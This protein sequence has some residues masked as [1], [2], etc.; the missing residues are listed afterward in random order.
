MVWAEAKLSAPGLELAKGQGHVQDS[1]KA[2]RE[3]KGE[4]FGE[5][6]TQLP[7]APALVRGLP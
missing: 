7:L 4:F 5:R 3:A 6:A 2:N 1:T